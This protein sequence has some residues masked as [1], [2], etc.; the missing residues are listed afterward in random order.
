MQ[1]NGQRNRGGRVQIL[2]DEEQDIVDT[3]EFA[4]D[5]QIPITDELH[6][7]YLR[8]LQKGQQSQEEG[9]NYER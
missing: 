9:G 7:E 8:I 3:V 5:W 1:S 6:E 4:V 2:T